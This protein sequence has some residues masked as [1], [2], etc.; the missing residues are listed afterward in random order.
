MKFW[1]TFLSYICQPGNFISMN[2][3]L[4]TTNRSL[5]HFF[6]PNSDHINH[7]F[8]GFQ[9]SRALFEMWAAQYWLFFY[10]SMGCIQFAN[11]YMYVWSQVHVS[12]QYIGPYMQCIC[13][14]FSTQQFESDQGTNK[15]VT[16]MLQFANNSIKNTK[17][18][19]CLPKKDLIIRILLKTHLIFI[20]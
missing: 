8:A 9:S 16:R 4:P 19:K 7:V 12:D 20:N 10:L 14:Q 13:N 15:T 3:K 5:L 6:N 11:I 1:L 18:W 17:I 2:R